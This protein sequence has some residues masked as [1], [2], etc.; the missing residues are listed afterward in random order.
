[1]D[2]IA[3]CDYGGLQAREITLL[4]LN[5]FSGTLRYWLKQGSH[6][7]KRVIAHTRILH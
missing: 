2:V 5:S 7:Y 3:K 4:K 6:P 1:M